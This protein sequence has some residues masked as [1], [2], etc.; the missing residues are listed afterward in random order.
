MVLREC[1]ATQ[2]RVSGGRT[3]AAGGKIW[4]HPIIS[5]SYWR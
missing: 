2:T 1:L 3:H 5:Q 4:L